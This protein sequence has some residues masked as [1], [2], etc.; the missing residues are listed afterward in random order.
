MSTLVTTV[1]AFAGT[2]VD[3]FVLLIVLFLV[4]REG[5]H[6]PWQ[7]VA[8]QYLVFGLLIALSA[9]AAAGLAAVPLAWVGL[10]GLVPLTLGVRGLIKAPKR[11]P[12]RPPVTQSF[13]VIVTLTSAT[14]ADN[15]SVYIVLLRAQPAAHAGFI[16]GLLLVLEALWC[17]AAYLVTSRK[18]VIALLERTEKWLVPTVFT[19]IGL[20]ILVRTGAITALVRLLTA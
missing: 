12:R 8:A 16:I 18:P 7:V 20:A 1:V 14:C 10:L 17:A 3:A 9:T 13:R 4:A 2:N 11:D 19:A 5:G 15:L 6:R